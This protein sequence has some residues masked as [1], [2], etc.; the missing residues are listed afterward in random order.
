MPPSRSFKFR[1]LQLQLYQI[2]ETADGGQVTLKIKRK[3]R[4]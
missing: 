1:I 2:Q 3:E 4:R